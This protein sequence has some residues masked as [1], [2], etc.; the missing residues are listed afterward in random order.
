[1]LHARC[2]PQVFKNHGWEDAF[3]SRKTGWAEKSFGTFASHFLPKPAQNKP[4]TSH[5]RWLTMLRSSE[6]SERDLQPF[7]FTCR[8]YQEKKSHLTLPW[9]PRQAHSSPKSGSNFLMSIWSYKLLCGLILSTSLS[10]VLASLQLVLC[11][12]QACKPLSTASEIAGR[13]ASRMTS[14]VRTVERH[15]IITQT[16]TSFEGKMACLL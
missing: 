7:L 10:E 15:V 14:R 9:V 16:N 11:L 3:V 6:S 5:H 1:M 12:S 2:L 4:W 13:E 8:N